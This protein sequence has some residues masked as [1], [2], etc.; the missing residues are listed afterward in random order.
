M[1][2]EFKNP[3][4]LSDILTMVSGHVTEI[5][6]KF[7]RHGVSTQCMDSSHV[8]LMFL[9]LAAADVCSKYNFTFEGEECRVGLSVANYLKVM[10]LV[11]KKSTLG[12]SY[13][14]KKNGDVITFACK[15]D[16]NNFLFDLKLMDLDVSE[17]MIPS[18]G[19][20]SAITFDTKVISEFFRG[21]KGDYDTMT[22]GVKNDSPGSL[23]YHATFDVGSVFGE[24]CGGV[25]GGGT[26]DVKHKVAF[27]YLVPYSTFSSE[28]SAKMTYS[29]IK[30]F[31]LKI[32]YILGENSTMDLYIAPKFED[33]DEK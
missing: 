13:D 12:L 14:P 28:H 19:T 2:L 15:C 4:L 16:K 23:L 11:D 31:P 6:L 18:H 10:K 21:F 7:T 33:E 5:E 8:S 17:L 9:E 1:E 3:F 25:S 32:S 26:E 29:F 27:K 22:I 20:P 24:L 30:N